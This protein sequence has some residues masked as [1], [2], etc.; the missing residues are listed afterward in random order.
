MALLIKNLLNKPKRSLDMNNE[1]KPCPCGSTD[2]EVKWDKF[3]QLC[4]V[5]CNKC[6]RCYG[7]SNIPEEAWEKWN[8]RRGYADTERC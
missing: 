3:T 1:N 8:E 6:L 4:A 5:C 7:L 2:L